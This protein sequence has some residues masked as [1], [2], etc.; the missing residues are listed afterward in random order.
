MLSA[1]LNKTFPSFLYVLLIAGPPQVLPHLSLDTIATAQIVALTENS[2]SVFTVSELRQIYRTLM[3][4]QGSPCHDNREPHGTRFKEHLLNLLL[5]WTEGKEIFISINSKVA[6]LLVKAHHSQIGQD[7]ALLLMRAA[8]IL[9]KCCLLKQEPFDVSF[10]QDCLTTP[11][12]YTNH[13]NHRSKF[14]TELH[15]ANINDMY[16][17]NT[18]F[19]HYSDGKKKYTN[20]V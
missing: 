6:D 10:P 11:V 12:P 4:E 13:P 8:V 3:V 19:R 9:R 17:R 18:H 16:F 1:S 20:V 7:K 15:N 2:D 14:Y 5:G